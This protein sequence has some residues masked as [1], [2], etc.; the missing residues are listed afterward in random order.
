[1][2]QRDAGGKPFGYAGDSA[3]DRPIFEASHLPIVVG[4]GARLAGK[5]AEKALVVP[6]KTAVAPSWIRSLRP[7]QWSKNV[8]VFAPAIAAHR[9]DELWPHGMLAFA[10]FSLVASAFYLL[11][12]FCDIDLDRQHPDKRRRA[13]ASGAL[14]P[15]HALALAAT[16]LAAAV[17]VSF[18]LPPRFG[19][20][21]AG[22]GAL[23]LLYSAALKHVKV[24]DLITLAFLYM[25]R[26][27]AG[28]AACDVVVSRWLFLFVFFLALSLAHLKRYTE[29]AQRMQQGIGSAARPTYS[30][31]H[32]SL[33]MKLGATSGLAS[34]LVL[35]LYI[36]SPQTITLY[37]HSAL[38][39]AVC[40]FLFYWIERIWH[41]ARTNR[42]AGDPISFI[43][44]D[45]MSYL[46]AVATLFVAWVASVY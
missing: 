21:L 4:A 12:D 3:A 34:V 17:G 9:L 36:S 20:I 43:V 30:T 15:S 18:S 2:I 32:T 42:I 7:H 44:T 6:R 45:A 27:F 39:F 37:H 8:L 16:L 46:V 23:N 24:L 13:Q 40:L 33:L 19:L 22:Y 14:C 10:A 11:N 35:A 1:M 25:L 29:L 38:L 5:K 28:G 41:L 31:A 26:I